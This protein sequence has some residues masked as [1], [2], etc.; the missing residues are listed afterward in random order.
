MNPFRKSYCRLYQAI[1]SLALPLLP[2]HDP[3]LLE[4]NGKLKDEVPGL[5]K[6]HGLSH[7]L[8]VIDSVLY[9]ANI[10]ES[11]VLSLKENGLTHSLFH[12]IKAEPT[13]AVVEAIVSSYLKE[14][15][16]CLVA[17]GGG[18][19]LDAAKAAGARLSN[20][21]RDLAHLK[22]VLRVKKRLPFFVAVP[23][24]AGTGSEAT[25]SAVITNEATLDKFAINDPKLIPDV[26]VLDDAYLKSL[27]KR[28]IANTGLDALTHAVE[29][30]IN[31]HST[32]KTR[33]YALSSI[34]LISEYLL[35]FYQD[36]NDQEARHGMLKASYFAGLSF[37]RAYVG[38]V[39]A[40][41]HS[42]GGTY[43]LPHGYLCAIALPPVL[44]KYTPHA[45]KRIAEIADLL[46][47]SESS[48]KAK[49]REAFFAWLSDL[50]QKL[51]IPEHL[52]SIIKEED[53]PA[54]AA[55]ADK[56]ANPLYPCPAL[57]DQKELVELLEEIRG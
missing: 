51:E 44:R 8:I 18:S 13:F 5:L 21:N 9:E 14:D 55:H 38:Y 17:I 19:C 20:P 52:S 23:T 41:A 29:S 15:C 26:A 16:D 50:Y 35:R 11:F 32:R 49:K 22:G 45:D 6:A 53:I 31:H 2:F 47:L 27:P 43:H 28:V 10:Q 30:Y 7:P 56:E 42:L 36:A 3:M 37:T 33:L 24:T 54:M 1:L 46:S 48:D 39:H 12:D 34:R 4:G 57:F 40:L 25:V